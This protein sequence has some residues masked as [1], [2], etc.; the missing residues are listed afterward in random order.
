MKDGFERRAWDFCGYEHGMDDPC[1][2]CKSL[3][4]ALREAHAAGLE[5][6]AK[7]HR[8]WAEELEKRNEDDWLP[9]QKAFWKIHER[10]SRYFK[11]KAAAL[12]GKGRE[13]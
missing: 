3:A 7:Y 12:R 10:D 1:S 9:G 13:G 11:Y 5:D 2:S 6:A 4:Q 8:K